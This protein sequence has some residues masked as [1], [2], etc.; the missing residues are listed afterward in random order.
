MTRHPLTFAAA[1]EAV[2]TDS[3]VAVMSSFVFN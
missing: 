2:I 1:P 3:N